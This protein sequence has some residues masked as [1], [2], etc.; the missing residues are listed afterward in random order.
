METSK[1]APK[2]LSIICEI[3]FE[4]EYDSQ[5]SKL[6]SKKDLLISNPNS[7]HAHSS[8]MDV[9]P[10]REEHIMDSISVESKKDNIPNANLDNIFNLQS[11]PE[12]GLQLFEEEKN[13]NDPYDNN[14]NQ[15][16][17]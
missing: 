1:L 10:G 13:E 6:I 15:I 14:S 17:Q 3:Q 4:L 7:S 11:I 2:N 16:V 8:I 9:E 5:K 12:P